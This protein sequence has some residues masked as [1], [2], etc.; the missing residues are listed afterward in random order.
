MVLDLKGDDIWRP[1]LRITGSSDTWSVSHVSDNLEEWNSRHKLLEECENCDT[2]LAKF[3][4]VVAILGCAC[5]FLSVLFGAAA[6]AR[7]QLMKKSVTKGPYKVLLTATDFVFPQIADSRRV[8]F[9]YTKE[10]NRAN[11]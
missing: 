5:L 9:F 4:N 6:L 3:V 10:T 2:E 8:R 11:F 1:L 7:R